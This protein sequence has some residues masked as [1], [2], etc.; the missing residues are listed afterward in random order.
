M[1][2]ATPLAAEQSEAQP[3][4][5]SNTLQ[6]LTFSIAAEEYGVDI[7]QVRE[8]KSWHGATPLP[9]SP[10]HVA[11]VINLR[12]TVIPIICMRALFGMPTMRE[13]PECVADAVVI[14]ACIKEVESTRTV[15]LLVDTVSEVY[16]LNSEQMQP[17]PQFRLEEQRNAVVALATIEEKML[18]LLDVEKVLQDCL[19][20]SGNGDGAPPVATGDSDHAC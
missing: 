11:G 12:G 9:N 5:S 7:L 2:T 16:T 3:T 1:L 20:T 13:A 18:I 19:N 4:Q 15:G 8:I 10:P 17:P 6:V 14:V